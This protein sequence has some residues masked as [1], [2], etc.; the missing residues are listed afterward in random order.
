[1]G[2]PVATEGP[3]IFVLVSSRC[4]MTHLK[5]ERETESGIKRKRKRSRKT[6]TESLKKID[7]GGKGKK[8]A[9]G[10]WRP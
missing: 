1:M 5:S 6:E 3:T 9:L 7:V 4:I 8:G 10:C 2:G